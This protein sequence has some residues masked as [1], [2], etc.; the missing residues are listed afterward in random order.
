MKSVV[1]LQK[2]DYERIWNPADPNYPSSDPG[3]GK[4]YQFM[5]MSSLDLSGRKSNTNTL[6]RLSS[7]P[8]TGLS[9]H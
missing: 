8:S 2:V 1:S 6:T 7:S 4:G 3:R 9:F 5:D